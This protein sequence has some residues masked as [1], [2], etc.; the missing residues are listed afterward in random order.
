MHALHTGQLGGKTLVILHD[1]AAV[2][3]LGLVLSGIVIYWR[4]WRKNNN[5]GN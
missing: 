4:L 3:L 2:C 1:L 5:S